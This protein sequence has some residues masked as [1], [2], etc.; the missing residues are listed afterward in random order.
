MSNCYLYTSWQ[1]V[2]PNP[3]LL[4]SAI[5]RQYLEKSMLRSVNRLDANL[6]LINLLIYT[7]LRIKIKGKTLSK[8]VEI[9]TKRMKIKIFK[10]TCKYL[11]YLWY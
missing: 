4:D 8:H 5:F 9:N 2:K 10:F 6:Y 7:K 11:S 3:L 1:A